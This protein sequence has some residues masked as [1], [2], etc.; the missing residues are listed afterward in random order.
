MWWAIWTYFKR[1]KMAL[2]CLQTLYN[3]KKYFIHLVHI[4]NG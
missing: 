4:I 3:C 1:A 2:T